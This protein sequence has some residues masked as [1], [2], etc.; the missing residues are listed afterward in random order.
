MVK[1][2]FADVREVGIEDLLGR[3]SVPPSDDL[4]SL[5]ISNKVVMVTGGGGSIGSELCRQIIK[6][7]P[8]TLIICELS[9]FALYS[10][11]QELLKLMH[12][13]ALPCELVVMLG[14]VKKRDK[15]D[16]GDKEI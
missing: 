6:Q 12:S 5:C 16:L 8:K 15:I 1:S 10:I 4:L 9:E 14:D 11:E 2:L 3:D 7:K 13:K